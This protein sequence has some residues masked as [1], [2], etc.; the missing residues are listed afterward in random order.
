[1][2]IRLKQEEIVDKK[3]LG[4]PYKLNGQ[5]FENTDCLK[6]MALYLKENGRYV[7]EAAWQE[8][9]EDWRDKDS[10]RYVKSL[11]KEGDIIPLKMLDKF[12]IILFVFSGKRRNIEHAGIMVNKGWF[13]H[14]MEDGVSE[15]TQLNKIWIDK[16]GATVRLG[17][18]EFLEPGQ[19]GAV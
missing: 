11:L 14:I 8:I 6:L 18:R 12:D 15:V 9:S 17:K 7:P 3:F 1:M 10:E 2:S 19:E 5:G 4:I 16:I 13:L